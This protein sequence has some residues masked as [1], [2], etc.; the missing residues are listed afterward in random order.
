MRAFLA[1]CVIGLGVCGSAWAQPATIARPA[2]GFAIAVPA[3]WKEVTAEGTAVAL[4]RGDRP[5]VR[6]TVEVHREPVAAEVTAV[7]ARLSVRLGED[8][9]RTVVSSDFAVVHDRPALV[10]EL[11]DTT[12]RYRVTVLPREAEATSQ[13]YVIVTASAPRAAY[14]AQKAS[15]DA[16]VGALQF[17]AVGAAPAGPSAA[18]PSAPA[19]TYTPG[20][21]LDRQRVFDRILAPR[22]SG[23]R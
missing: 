3:G 17:T 13:I 9:A 11:E 5:N 21:P 12:T 22:P 1:A 8:A 10:A 15:F 2:D 23:G 14:A 20:A 7:L 19:S 18:T 4:A 6:V 16:L